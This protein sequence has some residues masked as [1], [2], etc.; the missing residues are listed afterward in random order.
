MKFL[1]ANW[2]KISMV[3]IGLYRQKHNIQN[4]LITFLQIV[5]KHNCLQIE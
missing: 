2:P 1:V 4:V 3:T 5:C